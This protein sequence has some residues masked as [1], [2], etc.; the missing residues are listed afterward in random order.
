MRA[1]RV[2]PVPSLLVSQLH[3]P[4]WK[5]PMP[6]C[7]CVSCCLLAGFIAH[8]TGVER[9]PLSSAVPGSFAGWHWRYIWTL[10][11]VLLERQVR[12]CQNTTVYTCRKKKEVGFYS[13]SFRCGQLGL[14][15]PRGTREGTEWQL[16]LVQGDS[17]FSGH[18]PACRHL[19]CITLKKSFLL[20]CCVCPFLP[21]EI[22]WKSHG[23]DT[24]P[25]PGCAQLTLKSW[26]CSTAWCG[27]KLQKI[28]TDF[29]SK[30]FNFH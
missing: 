15:H 18:F 8:A 22:C 3:I 9:N 13:Q 5:P 19:F 17:R 12:I 25:V 30:V 2:I 23:H 29:C 11:T 21:K 16:F 7:V 14:A 26:V 20:S 24:Q 6:C 28:S 27:L 10:G 4:S 1:W